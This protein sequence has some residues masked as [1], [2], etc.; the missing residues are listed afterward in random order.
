MLLI[1]KKIDSQ[2]GIWYFHP[3]KFEQFFFQI[4]N[5][6]LKYYSLK[7]LNSFN[8]L[9]NLINHKYLNL[10]LFIDVSIRLIILDNLSK[11]DL[12]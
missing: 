11:A 1:F 7:I 6:Y 12:I 5:L 10:K 2:K 3:K 9:L 8:F 4:K